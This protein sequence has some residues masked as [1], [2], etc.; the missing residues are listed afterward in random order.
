MGRKYRIISGDGHVETPPEPWVSRV[1]E[2][3]RNRAPRLIKL[4]D[5]LGDAWIVE[6]QGI[7]HT[8]Q[9]VTGRGPVKFAN[10]SY[11]NEDGT[12]KEGTGD[13]VQRLHEQDL[14][15][16]DAEV[17]FPP[18]FATR[19][20]QGIADRDAYLAMVQGYNTFLAE[21]YCSVA[22]DRLIGAAFI[23]VSGIDDAIGELERAKRLGLKTVC[24]QQ[25]PNGSGGPTAEDDR[26]WERALELEM[27]LSPHIGFGD[28]QGPHPRGPSPSDA[29]VA[30]GMTQHTGAVAPAYCM[31]QM[32]VDGVFERF[33][34]L[35][36]Y[37]AEVN[38]A[39]LPAMMHYM[40]RDYLGYN[41]WFQFDLPMLPSEYFKIH[42]LFGMIR[43]P[44]A[45]KMGEFMPLD[46]FIWASD[47]P[48]SVGTYPDSRGYIEEAFAHLDQATKHRILLDNAAEHLHLDLS[49]DI[50]E[51]PAA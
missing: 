15:G 2:E 19:F 6:G 51:T 38:C 18:V 8:G 14:D 35:R 27:A 31:A 20:I 26:F 42:C 4:P 40:D 9:N 33:P 45:L 34:Q 36:F 12:P 49:A 50:T 47:F 25:F 7:L 24:L 43:E 10:A 39:S 17:L 32:I 28:M 23:P 11:F 46:W 22:P 29:K 30:G 3:H 44:L 21:D 5:G 41:D 16:I 1:A 13:A 37:F 48:H